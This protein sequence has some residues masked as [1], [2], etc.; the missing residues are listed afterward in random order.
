[1]KISA[2]IMAKVNFLEKFS[3]LKKNNSSYETISILIIKNQD[4]N[5]GN[6]LRREAIFK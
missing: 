4:L 1:M 2:N 6:T 3:H 5:F